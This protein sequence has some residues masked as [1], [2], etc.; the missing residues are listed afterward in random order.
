W[1]GT[2]NGLARF[3]GVQFKVFDPGNTPGLPG[4]GILSLFE[5]RKG[6]P[7]IGPVEGGLV[8]RSNGSVRVY[9]QGGRTSAAK[10]P[11]SFVE[12]GDGSLWLLSFDW[13][14]MRFAG[15]QLTTVST[16]WSLEG[17]H[18]ASMG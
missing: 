1:L 10:A 8:E 6:G 16:N 15:G 13:Q 9:A 14:L 4:N 7:W 11:R 18:V 5:R 17:T 2:F 3:D 12:S